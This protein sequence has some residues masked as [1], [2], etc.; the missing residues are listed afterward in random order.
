MQQIISSTV[1]SKGQVLIPKEIRDELGLQTYSRV[2]FEING[3][4]ATIKRAPT[5]DD[6][7]GFAKSKVHLTDSQLRKAIKK[8]SAQAV[9]EKYKDKARFS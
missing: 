2:V 5:V 3:R 7:F 1:T 8:A 9:M 4:E 6:M